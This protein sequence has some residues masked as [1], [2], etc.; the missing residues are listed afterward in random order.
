VV[1]RDSATF[2]SKT[3]KGMFGSEGTPGVTVRTNW[4]TH[5]I[6]MRR[7]FTL[8]NVS[9]DL[10]LK[11]FHDYDAKVFINGVLAAD[12]DGHST[13]FVQ[14]PLLS[15]AARSLKAG[16]NTIAVHCHK[17][18]GGQ[19]IDA[20]ISQFIRDGIAKRELLIPP[21]PKDLDTKLIPVASNAVSVL[22]FTRL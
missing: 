8:D 22:L 19:G 16:G 6:W 13:S 9:S 4:T 7:T 21:H 2:P 17:V 5:D 12:L 11:V 3:G 18:G 14:V 15:E 10:V 20:G 1:S